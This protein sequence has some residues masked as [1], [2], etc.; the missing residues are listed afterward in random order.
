ML[1]FDHRI[2]VARVILEDPGSVGVRRDTAR[3]ARF[4]HYSRVAV[5]GDLSLGL[6]DEAAW[7]AVEAGI[8][9]G[10][11]LASVAVGLICGRLPGPLVWAH[12][13]NDAVGDE[14]LP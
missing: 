9:V 6:S 4:G 13:Q 11:I 14:D 1:P 12:I 8:I 3:I 7:R 2:H 10:V 5:L